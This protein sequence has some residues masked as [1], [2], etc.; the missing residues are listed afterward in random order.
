MDC[1]KYV[2][3]QKRIYINIGKKLKIRRKIRSKM[4]NK[5]KCANDKLQ[6]KHFKKHKKMNSENIFNPAKINLK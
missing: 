1:A 2:T 6:H 4:C 5:I 3:Q